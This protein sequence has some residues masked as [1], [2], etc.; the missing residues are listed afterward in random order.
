[1]HPEQYTKIESW[2]AFYEMFRRASAVLPSLS[3]FGV[4]RVIYHSAYGE[5]PPL[6]GA[7]QRAFWSTPRHGRSVRDEF[8]ELRTAMS[9]AQSLISLGS[10]PLVVVTA[11]KEAAGGWI[12][13]QDELAALST[14]AAHRILP[15]AIH[16]ALTENEA[17][18]AQSSRAIR[19]VVNSVRNGTPLAG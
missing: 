17:L 14:N 13:A 18:A 9:Q 12:A 5:L 11:Q 16:A 7:E 15:D 10:R 3:R 19:D 2:P 6:A 4:G 1:M 8:S